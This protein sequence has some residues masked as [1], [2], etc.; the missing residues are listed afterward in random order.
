[1]VGKEEWG[2]IVCR[3]RI[4]RGEVGRRRLSES[5]M[6]VKDGWKDDVMGDLRKLGQIKGK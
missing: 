3:S 5:L 1:M 4:G 2:R 6:V